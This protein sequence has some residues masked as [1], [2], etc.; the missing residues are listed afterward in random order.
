MKFPL[1]LI[2]DNLK[3]DF[4][5]KRWIAFSFSIILTIA[6]IGLLC[7]KGLNFGID[8]TGGILIDAKFQ[9][10]P[11][12]AKMR[13]LLKESNIGEVSLQSFGKENNVLIRIGQTS[14]DEQER[15]KVVN[16]VKQVLEQNFGSNIEYRKVD[17]VGPKVGNELIKSGALALVLTLG[18]IMLYI[19]L[20]FEWQYGVAGIVAL[21]HD[22]V[23]TLGFLS[24]TQLDFDLSTIAAIL[25]IIGY[26]INDS[27]V[28][29]DRIRENMRKFK[30]MG[31]T[32]LLNLS[33]NE[34]MARTIMTS[35]T[36]LVSVL[37]LVLVGGEVVRSFSLAVLFGIAVGTYSSIYIGS[38]V[39]IYMKLRNSEENT[40]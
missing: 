10:A 22:A 25:T 13:T 4:M 40:I 35:T 36:T 18:A 31:L 9:E 32:E 6:T 29:F 7:T 12:L 33:V 37:A 39:L 27:V 26:S 3:I 28:I 21:I 34:T 20:R 24:L 5:G 15:A 14:G 23:L 19:W 1:K 30:K 11:E 2:P 8:F 38:P 16:Q 17:Y